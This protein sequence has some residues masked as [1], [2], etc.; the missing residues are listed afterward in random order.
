MSNS[1]KREENQIV[2]TI[3]EVNSVV[4]L[5]TNIIQELGKAISFVIHCFKCNNKPKTPVLLRHD[6]VE[7]QQVSNSVQVQ[8]VCATCGKKVHGF[9]PL[10]KA[11]ELIPGFQL[12]PVKR[13]KDEDG[14]F[15]EPAP[16]QKKYK[17][18]EVAT[19]V[20]GEPEEGVVENKQ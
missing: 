5:A 12:V 3:K 19:A 4:P 6:S 16:A 2:E 8:G 1:E 9:I 7:I 11:K 20:V 10:T 15:A 14:E 18:A 13:K 17:P